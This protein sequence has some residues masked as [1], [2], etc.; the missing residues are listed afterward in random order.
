MKKE[1][2]D[3]SG[4]GVKLGHKE[5]SAAKAPNGGASGGVNK[6]LSSDMPKPA[7]AKGPPLSK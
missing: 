5:D 7:S 6:Y 2:D 1:R 4:S 3:D